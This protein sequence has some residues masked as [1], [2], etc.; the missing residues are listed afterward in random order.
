MGAAVE[1]DA[2]IDSLELQ[3]H[4]EGGW[5]RRVWTATSS[6]NNGEGRATASAILYLLEVGDTSAWHRLTDAEEVWVH[7]DGDPLELHLSPDGESERIVVIGPAGVPDTVPTAT[8]PIGAW[9]S[10]EVSI[11]A[12]THGWSLVSCVVSPEFLF[13]RFEL[14]PPCWS[15]GG[16]QV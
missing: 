10:A 16:D 4:P 12:R 15:P 13:E 9:Q 8:V 6:L 11:G 3:P 1:L 5:Y 14:A 7:Q 2:I